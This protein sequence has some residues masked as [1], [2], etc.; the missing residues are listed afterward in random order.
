M[1]AGASATVVE[2]RSRAAAAVAAVVAGE[3]AEMMLVEAG[4]APRLRHRAPQ[5]CIPTCAG[6]TMDG[7]RISAG[8]VRD[9]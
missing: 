3:E 7:K 6:G 4:A 8:S 5:V 9:E 1:H 2:Q